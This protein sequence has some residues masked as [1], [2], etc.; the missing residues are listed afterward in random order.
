MP[1]FPDQLQALADFDAAVHAGARAPI[2]VAPTG[3][4]KTHTAAD[5][6]A[7][8]IAAGGRAWFLAHLQE[9]LIDTAGRLA[10]YGIEP[11]WIWADRTPNPRADCQ[12]VS[13]QSAAAR[14]DALGPRPDLVIID[15]CHRATAPTYQAVLD[16]LGRPLVMGLSG[17]PI[18]LDGRPLRHGGFDALIRTSDTID[19]I[20]AGRLSPLKAWSFPA[21]GSLVGGQIMEGR[22]LLG[23]ALEHWADRARERPTAI[24]CD[25]V[26]AARD[27]AEEWRR[28]GFRALA[29]DGKS[30]ANYRCDALAA[31]RAHAIDALICADLYVAGLDLPDLGCVVCLRPTDS[32]VVWLQMAGRGLRQSDVWPDCY[33]HDHAGN[34]RR[35]GLGHPLE[36]R[37][38]LWSLDG[39]PGVGRGGRK[40]PWDDILP[41]A[42]CEKCYSCDMTGNRCNECGHVKELRIPPGMRV[43]DGELVAV[44]HQEEARQTRAQRAR[45]ESQCRTLQDWV[46]LGEHRGYSNPVGWARVRYGLRSKQRVA[47]PSR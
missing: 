24:F 36:R 14:I 46:S 35:P 33:L 19:L 41:A 34:C 39:V 16:A 25:G 2:I 47:H 27:T 15:E 42:Y 5:R 31:A 30:G 38:H 17:T 23:N 1:L 43:V 7:Q 18:R 44:D 12:L 10:E 20:E 8:V 22:Y 21:P 6:M 11:G 13:L 26:Q 9:L 37:M 32:L 40:N 4:G 29:V 28:V 3:F 45:E